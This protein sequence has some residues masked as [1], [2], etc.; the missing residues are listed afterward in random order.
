[1]KKGTKIALATKLGFQIKKIYEII[2]RLNLKIGEIYFETPK[3]KL[4]RMC[5]D[6]YRSFQVFNLNLSIFIL[7]NQGRYN[8][9]LLAVF[10]LIFTGE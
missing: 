2:S 5:K 9:E 7:F 1:M 3:Y 6:K 8:C 10:T 4:A